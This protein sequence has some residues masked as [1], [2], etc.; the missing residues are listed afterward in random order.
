DSGKSRRLPDGFPRDKAFAQLV[1]FSG[2]AVAA[3]QKHRLAMAIAP[4]DAPETNTINT[5]AE[6][7]KLAQAVHHPAFGVAVDYYHL[8]LAHEDPRA[9][10]EA[11]KM[12]RHVRIANPRGRAFPMAAGEAD[13]ASFFAALKKIGYHGGIGVE[14][15]TTDFAAEAP[16]AVDFLRA[17]AAGLR[18]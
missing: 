8:M 17:Q 13:Y 1:E 11:G 9:I 4:L 15:H 14:A 12:L 6:A 10:L 3:A 7:V 16:R 18:P 2:R 5:V